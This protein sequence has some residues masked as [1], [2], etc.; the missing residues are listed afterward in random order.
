MQASIHTNKVFDGKVYVKGNPNTCMNDIRG[1]L[2]FN[3]RM[4]YDDLDCKVQRSE[5][6]KYVNNIII[7][8]H[9]KII[10]RSDL[11]LAVTCR[12]DLTNKKVTNEV[13]LG[14]KGDVEPTMTEEVIVESPNV[15]MKI[16]DRNGNDAVPTAEVGDALALRFEIIDHSSPY[17]IFVRELIAMDGVDSNEIVLIDSRG[18]PADEY[19]MGP[20]YKHSDSG[21][22][23]I[24]K[25]DAFKFPSS[26]IV[27]F[28]ALVTPCIPSCEPVQCDQEDEKSGQLISRVSYGKKRRRRHA[29]TAAYYS[30]SQNHNNNNSTDDML[31][32]QTIHITD[33]FSYD[34]KN[35]KKA[36]NA[37]T[38]TNPDATY[39]LNDEFN[40]NG[41]GSGSGTTLNTLCLNM[42]GIIGFAVAFLILQLVLLVFWM[43]ASQKR[44]QQQLELQQQQMFYERMAMGSTTGTGLGLGLG[45]GSTATINIPSNLNDSLCKLYDGSHTSSKQFQAR[46]F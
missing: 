33:K 39:Y 34:N 10:T 1:D 45:L 28:R 6:G 31:L 44:H 35:A 46:R 24:S 25:F 20:I 40:S 21:K 3:L 26:D 42:T 11:A 7:Q 37:S 19:I 14:V 17:E 8:H 15:A 16:T 2:E 9:D 5:N 32:V 23:L 41:S 4:P 27:Q 38:T 29:S 12:F 30:S 36:P 22:I 18:C 13:D 43:L